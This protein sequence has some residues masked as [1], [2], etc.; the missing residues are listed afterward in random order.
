MGGRRS[1]NKITTTK[2]P[3]HLNKEGSFSFVMPVTLG[4]N[5][6][7]DEKLLLIWKKKKKKARLLFPFLNFRNIKNKLPIPL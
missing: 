2:N 3:I 5:V 4:D 6:R 7:I 1:N